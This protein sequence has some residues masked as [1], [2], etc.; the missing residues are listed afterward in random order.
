MCF[1]LLAQIV[2]PIMYEC[3]RHTSVFIGSNY[4]LEWHNLEWHTSTNFLLFFWLSLFL[5]EIIQDEVIMIKVLPHYNFEEYV[6]YAPS[7]LY[8]NSNR[9]LSSAKI[10][11]GFAIVRIFMIESLILILLRLIYLVYSIRT[12]NDDDFV[13]NIIFK[14][15]VTKLLVEILVHCLEILIQI[16]IFLILLSIQRRKI[17]T[18]YKDI[19]NTWSGNFDITSECVICRDDFEDDNVVLELSCHHIFHTNCLTEWAQMSAICRCPVCLHDNGL[20]QDII[21]IIS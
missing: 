21:D 19:K 14:I 7:Q 2:S 15:I 4:N 5:L 13:V 17:S 18:T 3:I 6:G 1:V 9:L 11:H 16:T 20:S 8:E 10:K 12:F